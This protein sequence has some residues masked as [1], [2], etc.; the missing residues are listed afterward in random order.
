MTSTPHTSATRARRTSD[1]FKL[2]LTCWIVYSLHFATNIVREHYPAFSLAE[3]GTLRVDPYLGLHPDLFEIEGRGAF[4]NNNP[5]ASIIA[6]LPYAL[7]RPGIDW[8]VERTQ[9]ARAKS[10]AEL[11][12]DYDDHR[13]NRVAFF[14]K[15]RE[16]GLDVR[17][18]LAGAAIQVFCTA[19][20]SAA[21]VVTMRTLLLQCGFAPSAALCLALLYAF[22]TPIFFRSAHLNHNL[23]AAHFALMSFTLLHSIGSDEAV[24]RKRRFAAGVLAGLGVLCDYSGVVPL[25]ALSVYALARS[26]AESARADSRTSSH[27]SSLAESLRSFQESLPACFQML[28][29]AALPIAGLLAY[30]AWAFGNPFL[31]AQYYMPATEFSGAGWKG[32]A[33]PA[34]DL[35]YSNLFDLR[36]G[37]FAFGPIL[38]FALAAPWLAPR[39]QRGVARVDV[40]LALGLFVALL[41]FTSA[42][43]F[44]RLQWNTGFRMLAP[45]VPFLFLCTSAVLVRLPRTLAWGLGLV[46]TAHAWTLAMVREDALESPRIVLSEGLARPWLTVFRKTSTGYAPWMQETAPVALLLFVLVS[47]ALVIVWGSEIRAYVVRRPA[48]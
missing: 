16:R 41:L 44:A 46:A 13:P 21:A 40:S 36:Y 10:G 37:L 12:T 35:V 43:Q 32:L 6:A 31:P 42:N 45:A 26:R 22:G 19:P 33:W 47:L 7:V 38:V 34:A 11:P 18:G 39:G 28:A 9:R 23:F 24:R 5:G 48:A 1:A 30:Q 3:S 27:A 4:I 8:V 14:K 17:F 29:G 25:A 15:V 2:F 20:L